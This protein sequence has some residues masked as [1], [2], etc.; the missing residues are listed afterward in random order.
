[1]K[2]VK[3]QSDIVIA[4][5]QKWPKKR[6]QLVHLSNER[7]HYVQAFRA[8]AIGIV[9]GAADLIFFSKKFNVATEL[10]LPGSRHQVAHIKKQLDWAKVWEAEG[11]TWRLCMTVK[12]AMSCY[13][14]KFKGMTIKQ[15][16][17]KINNVTTKTI[18]F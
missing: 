18:K 9:P 6:G 3:L 16:E 7:N 14:G 1:M 13:K 5:S 4:F 11:N 10:K 15:V 2:E 17:R 8:K 12:E